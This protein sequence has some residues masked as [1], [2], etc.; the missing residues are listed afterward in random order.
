MC[1]FLV[2]GRPIRHIFHRFQN[3]RQCV[4]AGDENCSVFLI[5]YN[6]SRVFDCSRESK[7]SSSDISFQNMHRCLPISESRN[8][9]HLS[10]ALFALKGN[11]TV[12]FSGYSLVS[13][14]RGGGLE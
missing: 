7:N 9:S 3:G 12:I 14:R 6:K 5:T 11:G 13:N 1:C 4:K 8:V 2:S 10:F